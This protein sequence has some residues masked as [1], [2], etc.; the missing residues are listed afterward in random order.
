MRYILRNNKQKP[1]LWNQSVSPCPYN[2]ILR[3]S[4]I[5]KVEPVYDLLNK[6]V[7]E[8]GIVHEDLSIDES[9]VPYHDS[10]SNV[11][12]QFVSDKSYAY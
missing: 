3:E 5:A 10:H 4:H 8:C 11:Q 7:Q 12:S 6:K 9:M 1:I 2:Q